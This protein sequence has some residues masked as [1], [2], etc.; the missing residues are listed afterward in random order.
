MFLKL[1][2]GGAGGRSVGAGEGKGIQL[3][4]GGRGSMGVCVAA[5]EGRCERARSCDVL[6]LFTNND[7]MPLSAMC[8][9]EKGCRL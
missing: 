1:V 3:R 6:P 9:P 7:R 2:A 8:V 4:C 5:E